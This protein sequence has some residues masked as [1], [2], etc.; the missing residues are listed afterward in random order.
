MKSIPN[1]NDIID[2]KYRLKSP[3]RE[4]TLSTLFLAENVQEKRDVA[5]RILNPETTSPSIEDFIRLK[6][7]I[8]I[9]N[10]LQ[11]PNILP[12]RSMG[13]H[14]N[15]IYLEMSI[16][17]GRYLSELV[18]D[19]E[20]F[21]IDQS[22][23]IVKE[24]AETLAGLHA[25]GLV[26]RDVKPGNVTLTV[27]DGRYETGLL[28]FGLA[29]VMELNR[30]NDEKGAIETFGYMSPEATGILKRPI[31]E[32][33]D[34]Y[35]LGII[36]Y[37]L[38]T[39][40]RP[41]EGKDP[42]TLIYQ[43]IAQE[44]A[45]PTKLNS[46]LPPVIE[47]IILRL[48]AKDPLDRY[49]TVTG[50]IADLNEYQRQRI[51]G[52][53]VPDFEIARS[54]RAGQLTF[55]TRLI[56]R[57]KELGILRDLVAQ[58]KQGK[59]GVALVHG[60]PGVGKSR[61]IDELRGYV[62][63]I[64]G[65]FVGGKCHQ[66]ELTTPFKV[67]GE[68]LD[69]YVRKLK[70][71]KKDERDSAAKR[72]QAVL[73]QLGEDVVKIAPSIADFIGRQ[74]EL[75]TLEAEKERVR[76]MITAADFLLSLGTDENPFVIFLDDLQW[77]DEGSIKL[78]RRI[79]EEVN[80][81]PMMIIASYRDTDIYEG[82]SW[83]QAVTETRGKNIPL[84][85]IPV[86]P[87]P[88]AGTNRIVSEILMEDEDALLPLARELHEKTEGNAFF[89][90]E[91]L[92]SLV[93]QKIIYF[94][95][96]HYRYDLKELRSAALPTNVIE[97]VIR[98]IDGI[99]AENQKVLA[100]SALMGREIELERISNLTGIPR[101]KV[102]DAIEEG[103][104]N[105][106]LVRQISGRENVVFMHDCIREALYEHFS[107]EER[108][109]LH[110]QI[111]WLLEEEHKNDLDPVCFEL[112]YHFTQA[113]IEE[114]ILLY[115]VDAGKKSQQAFAHD[116]AVRFYSVAKGILEKK[117]QTASGAYVDVL[118]KLGTAYDQAGKY[119]EALATLKR[120]ESLIA[121]EDKLRR[122][123]ILSIIGGTEQRK[124]DLKQS[125]GVN[126]QALK[127]LGVVIPENTLALVPGILNQILIQVLYLMLPGI[128]VRKEPSDNL[129]AATSVKMLTTLIYSY[130]WVDLLK[131]IY[132][133][134]R[135]ANIAKRRLGP[136]RA[137][138]RACAMTALIWSQFYLYPI[139]E[140]EAAAALRM[141]EDL[142]D[143]VAMGT[144][145]FFASVV[146]MPV[147][148]SDSLKHASRAV[149]LLK[150]IG[151]Y[152]D[153]S[154]NYFF[155]LWN[156][157]RT[158]VHFEHIPKAADEC[159]AAAKATK[160]AQSTG[161]GLLQRGGF[162]AY[163]GDERFKY[164]A[165][166][167][168]KEAL[169]IFEEVGDTVSMVLDSAFLALA[170]LRLR[171][172][173]EAVR[174]AEW[175]NSSFLSQNNC[176]LWT[177]DL[178]GISAKVCLDTVAEK[179]DLSM[180]ERKKYLKIARCLCLKALVMGML[181]PVYRGWS[182]QVNGKY[183]WLCGKR[184]KAVRTWDRGIAYLR[185]HTRDAYRLACILGEE[186]SFLLREDPKDKKAR[187]YLIEAREIFHQVGAKLDMDRVGNLLGTDENAVT[188]ETPQERLQSER[189]MAT[190]LHTSRYLSS[191]LD[192]NE[193]LEKILD[194]TMELVGAERGLLVLHTPADQGG[195]D[196]LVVKVVRS[197]GT[198]DMSNLPHWRSIV[199]S[200]IERRN[201]LIIR[202]ASAD[203]DF[204]DQP[205]I[206][207]SGVRSALC[208]PMI[209]KGRL[210]GAIYLD[211]HLVSG[212]FNEKDREMLELISSQAAVSVENARLYNNVI[213]NEK[214]L[215]ESEE[216]YRLISENASDLIAV[217][218]LGGVYTYVS[219]SHRRYGHEP[220]ELLGGSVLDF[221]HPGDQDSLKE[222]M[223]NH[224]S[225]R[226]GTSDGDK[227]YTEQIEFR[228]P[229][230]SGEWRHFG[231]TLNLVFDDS[232]V[233]T[234]FLLVS[235][236]ITRQKQAEEESKLRQEQLFQAAKM[237]SLGTLVSGVAHE[238][239][240]PMSYIMLNAP[241]LEK[242][243]KGFEPILREYYRDKGDFRIANMNYEQLRE[244]IPALLSDIVDGTRRVK[245]II[246][247]LKE[248]A[249]QAPPELDEP[250]NVNRVTERAI[251]LVSN[252]IKKTTVNFSVSCEDHVPFFKGNVQ[253][254]E[255]VIINLIVNACQALSNRQ[256]AVA[257]T[258]RY[259]PESNSVVLEVRDEGNGIPPH[260]LERIKDPFFTTKRETGGTG[261]GL[262]I[263]D[264]IIQDHG[265]RMEFDS[266]PGKGTTVTI[267]FE[268]LK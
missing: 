139:A 155:V 265:G 97:A 108:A 207:T 86:K 62:H 16:P 210:I 234:A 22:V 19:S 61:L 241:L 231:S 186:G 218:T 238:I 216:K 245:H 197:A 209:T 260:L 42:S 220:D 131:T 198:E 161:H 202:D 50:L 152:W 71:L 187:E 94:E 163:S 153:L 33:S 85:D 249:R 78:L 180:A 144:A 142:Q 199:W 96:N 34:I 116:Q 132:V 46:S 105:Q 68:A 223:G 80:S 55:A 128:F 27:S 93:D 56:G 74:P 89:V 37:Q 257:V 194:S 113:G 230:K 26:H 73:G 268:G 179:P 31:D 203:A 63:S 103:I 75:E 20:G 25:R 157:A 107:T 247:D 244:E 174:L 135:A 109:V 140:K 38:A 173:D 29:H 171:S 172:Y 77:A 1:V 59:G 60:S 58:A 217:T 221:V 41:Y 189:R 145:S 243:W 69:A 21:T 44:P 9:V 232:S 115:S 129:K 53:E 28:G 219:P 248:F 5:L 82:H 98:R 45:P 154:S 15:V 182:Y 160:A 11:H 99:S 255:Q 134:F 104:K 10:K 133:S 18:E 65:I 214:A 79:V 39:G 127:L 208:A 81:R 52:R 162:L 106:L 235:R 233:P 92:H 215:K 124:G 206:A 35:S 190:V 91:L 261:L 123:V 236:D 130:Y 48:I 191:I 36:L 262:A 84:T 170:H 102:V 117:N 211:N 138:V 64:G 253:R 205:A 166:E 159:L 32:R 158:G 263:S 118:E 237:A 246:K 222:F 122:A 76:F 252:L 100:Y 184:K 126:E 141:S 110:G 239:N 264:R 7:E 240:N 30:I 167:I 212:L 119:E 40:R 195:E 226:T 121:R 114:K 181:C 13:R 188:N 176:A 67:F 213:R 12:V 242:F 151:E 6:R 224:L 147:S 150:G 47:R 24:M 258:T 112:A 256:Q 70:C 149:E 43:H 183:Q 201:S 137:S 266:T 125:I 225:V 168:L 23:E 72:M 146:Y 164:E 259:I 227:A 250:I 228:F 156:Q 120:C 143:R 4:E 87:L 193:L 17:Q 101:E 8:E 66:Y 54:D 83:A 49:Q 148:S 136:C 178:L 185:E 165:V 57:D 267:S 177:L 51:E 3:L 88:P 169:R 2:Q 14:K 192:L 175:V 254:I 251:N 204:R 90:L 95:D 111:A 229:T 200:A 196:E